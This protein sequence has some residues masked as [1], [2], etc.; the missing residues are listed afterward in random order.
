MGIKKDIGELVENGIINEDVA[1]RIRQYYALNSAANSQSRLFLVFGIFGGLL[2]GLG[3]ILIIAHNWDQFSRG[4]KTAFAFLPLL[5]GQALCIYTLIR[6]NSSLAW[7]ETS[8]V[9][10]F[11]AVGGSI[12]LISQIYNIPGNLTN[13]LMVWMMLVLPQVYLLRSSATSLLSL[14][15]ITAFAVESNGPGFTEKSYFYWL[16]L[17]FILPFYKSLIDKA[18]GSNFTHFHHWFIALS[19]TISLWVFE[20]GFGDLLYMNYLLLMG[21]FQ[22][23]G[24]WLQHHK[25]IPEFN[26]MRIVGSVGTVVTLI[27][28]SFDGTWNDMRLSEWKFT[29]LWSSPEFLVFLFIS[30]LLGILY[31]KVRRDGIPDRAAIPVWVYCATVLIFIC[32]LFWN[33]SAVLVNLLVLVIGILKIREGALRD[34]LV[35]LNFGMLIIAL[36][37]TCRFFDT[38]LSFVVRG[39]LFVSVGAGFFAANYFALKRRKHDGQ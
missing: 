13:Y 26:G 2:V 39:I 21:L 36:L 23:Y 6:K 37:I 14:I 3:I 31:L 4:I 16:F 25:D 11:F 8:S 27:V 18:P 30:A 33:Y 38:D 19:V 12:S 24:Y 20:N 10:L 9:V 34:H 28:L 29:S 5:M 7:R 22:A 1:G 15:G 17:V 32:S 35:I